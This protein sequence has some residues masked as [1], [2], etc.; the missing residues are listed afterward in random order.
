MENTDSKE[1]KDDHIIE[2]TDSERQVADNHIAIAKDLFAGKI[3]LEILIARVNMLN[4]EKNFNLKKYYQD[5]K[6][7]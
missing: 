1:N 4:P 6:N 3:D 7:G 2:L 5:H